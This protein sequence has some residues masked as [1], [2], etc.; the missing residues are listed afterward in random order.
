MKKR[1]LLLV[2]AVIL[3][4]GGAALALRFFGERSGGAANAL[5]LYGNVEIREVQLAFQD[6][7]RIRHIAVD[8]GAAVRRGMLLAEIDPERYLLEV[9]RLEGETEAQRQ[10]LERLRQGSRPQEIAKAGAAVEAAGTLLADARSTYERTEKLFVLN[11]ISRQQ[12]DNARS[13]LAKAEAGLETARQ[14]LSLAVEGPRTEDIARAEAGL[15]AL[16]AA[17]ALTRRKYEDSRLLAPTDGI[18]HNRILEPGAMAAPG[19]PVLTLALSDPLWIRT[20]LTE[21]DLGRVRPGMR[22]EITTDSYPEKVYCGWV[23]FISPTAEFTPKTVETP[24]LRTRLV[25]RARVFACNPEGELR[26]GMPVTVTLLLDGSG[27]PLPPS[28]CDDSGGR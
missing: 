5:I 25:Y 9:R 12:V 6:A 27:G 20:Y 11:K 16:E 24:E 7:G 2:L 22:A 19:S 10:L 21:S 14:E 15:R 3:L 4:A 13:A 17:L 1:S 26:L 28:P 18:I 8:E 23:G